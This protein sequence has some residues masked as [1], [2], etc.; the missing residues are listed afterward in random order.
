MAPLKSTASITDQFRAELDQNFRLPLI[1]YFL[2]RVGDRSEAEDLTQEVFLRILHQANA[3]DVERAKAY[4]FTTAA[5]LLHDRRRRA[6]TRQTKA[7]PTLDDI[8]AHT[9]IDLIEDR[10]P[11]RVF[12]GRQTLQE[13]LAALND[14]SQRTRDIF[15]LFRLEQMKQQ[16]IAALFGISQSAVEKQIVKAVAFLTQRFERP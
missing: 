14:L 4:I 13:V 3:I 8:T 7:S 1:A 11:E 16:E 6:A 15:V 9:S 2:K 10:N 5:N 12:V